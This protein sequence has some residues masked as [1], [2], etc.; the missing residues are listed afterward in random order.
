MKWYKNQIEV[1]THGKGMYTITE[2]I[3]QQIRDR[4]VKEGICHL[5]VKHTSASLVINENYDPSAQ[6]DM[7]S[8][9]D[10]FVPEEQNWMM[11]TI[12]G[13]DDSPSH[14][15]TMLTN[16]SLSVPIENGRMCLGTWQ[17][18]YLF[19]HRTRPHTRQVL[20][21]VMSVDDSEIA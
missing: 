21:R 9:M 18:V 17:G 1:Q 5:Y 12:E 8:F 20:V 16:V 2:E 6:V 7:E 14:L 13:K 19:E 11:H 3:A 10:Q 4:K 15:R